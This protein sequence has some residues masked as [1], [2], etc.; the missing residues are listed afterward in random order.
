MVRE[1]ETVAELDFVQ[2]E[3]HSVLTLQRSGQ[4]CATMHGMEAS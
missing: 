3:D 2:I 1:L 4:V